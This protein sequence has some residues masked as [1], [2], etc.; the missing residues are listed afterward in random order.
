[1]MQLDLGWQEFSFG[2]T[3]AHNYFKII[4][5]QFDLSKKMR[6]A[7]MGLKQ[8]TLSLNFFE[9]INAVK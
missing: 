5:G 8:G 4:Y 3:L 9:I 6:E 7:I 1:M 2:I